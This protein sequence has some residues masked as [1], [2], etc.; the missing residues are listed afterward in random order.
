[1]LISAITCLVSPF[2]IADGRLYGFFSS[3]SA[4][5]TAVNH[6]RLRKGIR[7]RSGQLTRQKALSVL[8][9]LKGQSWVL[10]QGCYSAKT[11]MPTHHIPLS[12]CTWERT[13]TCLGSEQRTLI[14][15]YAREGTWQPGNFIMG[16]T[17]GQ[18]QFNTR[19]SNDVVR[20]ATGF[21]FTFFPL[22][23]PFSAA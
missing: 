10:P 17:R 18:Q 13:R 3:S 16:D 15:L 22:N 9:E 1:M 20:T 14:M 21:P 6:T 5:G 4:L 2:L 12:Q 7:S 19:S 11:S 23:I 8:C